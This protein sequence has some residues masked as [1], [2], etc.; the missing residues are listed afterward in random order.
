MLNLNDAIL[1]CNA[2]ACFSNNFPYTDYSKIVFNKNSPIVSQKDAEAKL[3]ELKTAQD[4]EIKQLAIDKAKANQKLL[5]L[6]LTQAE[7]DALKK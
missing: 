5:D 2:N 1:A 3:V 4:K 7:I 6:G